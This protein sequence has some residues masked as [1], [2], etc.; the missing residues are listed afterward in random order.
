MGFVSSKIHMILERKLIK[1]SSYLKLVMLLLREK[2]R[3]RE[4]GSWRPHRGQNHFT[5]LLGLS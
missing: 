5:V 4:R 3:R 2:E 1:L